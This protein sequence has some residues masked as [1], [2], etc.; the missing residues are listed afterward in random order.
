M[1]GLIVVVT[2][3]ALL[4]LVVASRRRAHVATPQ[5]THAARR[6]G[7]R[8]KG[9]RRYP[10]VSVN[11]A[12]RCCEGAAALDGVRFLPDEVPSLPLAGCTLKQC[13]CT[14]MHH[15]D[16]RSGTHDRRRLVGKRKDYVLFFGE[17][18]QREGRGRRASDWAAAY[19][20]SEYLS[21]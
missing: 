21:Y 17:E 3:I 5:S 2:A 19:E 14:Y 15:A 12:P 1:T 18:D 13:K 9:G 20:N 6:A 7:D 16:R 4:L 10:G 8:V 11:A